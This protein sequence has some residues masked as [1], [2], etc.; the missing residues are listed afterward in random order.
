MT[1]DLSD[2]RMFRTIIEAGSVTRA[3]EHLHTVQSNVTT[4]LRQLEEDLGTPCSTGS[5]GAW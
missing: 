4:R 2:L 3:A 1:M 5:T